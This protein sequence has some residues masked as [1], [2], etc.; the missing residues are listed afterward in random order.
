MG[1]IHPLSDAHRVGYSH[2]IRWSQAKYLA[3]YIY[4]IYTRKKWSEMISCKRKNSP[5]KRNCFLSNELFHVEENDFLAKEMLSCQRKWFPVKGN[6][7]MSNKRI[8]REKEIVFGPSGVRAL[9]LAAGI[10]VGGYYKWHFFLFSLSLSSSG[11]LLILR[12]GVVVGIQIFA[13]APKYK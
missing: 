6:Y 1:V 5:V 4:D 13:W 10:N 12:E 7:L 3:Y 2:K 11:S 9:P 8:F